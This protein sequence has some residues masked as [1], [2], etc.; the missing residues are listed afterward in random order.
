MELILSRAAAGER[1]AGRYGFAAASSFAPLG[2]V[3]VC[4]FTHG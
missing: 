1:I 3:L 4:F 2:V